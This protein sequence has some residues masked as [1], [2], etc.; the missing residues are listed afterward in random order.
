LSHRLTWSRKAEGTTACRERSGLSKTCRQMRCKTRAIWAR[1]D[2]LK[3]NL[4]SGR[5]SPI[6]TTSDI[7]AT[8]CNRFP[9]VWCNLFTVGGGRW[10][11][12]RRWVGALRRARTSHRDETRDCLRVRTYGNRA[13]V[14]LVRVASHQGAWEGH[15]QGEAA[16]EYGIPG[17]RARDV[18][19]LNWRNI[20]SGEPHDAETVPCGSGRGG[21]KRLAR[22]LA[23]RL[24]HVRRVAHD[25]IPGAARKNWEECSWVNGLPDGETQ[26]GTAAC[27]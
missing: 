7:D 2:C 24:L 18:R 26:N 25:G 12:V 4:Q 8:V 23:R 16:Q 14:L 17:G 21:E 20:S 9:R 10:G 19:I 3:P 13:L 15:V 1:L 5:G 6:D 11:Q 22:D 27:R